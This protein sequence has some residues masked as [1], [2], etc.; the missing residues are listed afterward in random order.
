M[1]F[2]LYLLCKYKY[3]GMHRKNYFDFYNFYVITL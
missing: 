3:N 2:V 1:F